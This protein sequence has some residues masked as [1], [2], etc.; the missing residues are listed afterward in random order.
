MYKKYTILKKKPRILKKESHWEVRG[1]IEAYISILC[2]DAALSVNLH[3]KNTL[4]ALV[5]NEV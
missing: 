4:P 2:P 3:A 1:L 5:M